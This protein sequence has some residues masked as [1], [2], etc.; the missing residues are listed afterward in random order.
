MPLFAGL[1]LWRSAESSA[2]PQEIRRDYREL[3]LTADIG[4][5]VS[6]VILYKETLGQSASDGTPFVD[7]LLERGILPGIKVDEVRFQQYPCSV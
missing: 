4:A 2:L 7:C 3:F 6:G 5:G 1:A